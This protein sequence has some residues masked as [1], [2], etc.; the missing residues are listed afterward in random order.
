VSPSNRNNNPPTPGRFKPTPTWQ[1]GLYD[2]I[3]VDKASAR[4]DGFR[5]AASGGTAGVGAVGGPDQ[6]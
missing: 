6:R 5:R 3:T 4:G 2:F 1:M